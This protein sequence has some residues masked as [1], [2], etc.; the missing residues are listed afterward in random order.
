MHVLVGIQPNGPKERLDGSCDDRGRWLLQSLTGVCADAVPKANALAA[1]VEGL[2]G[3]DS[4]NMLVRDRWL[5]CQ[6]RHVTSRGA[7]NEPRSAPDLYQSL[8]MADF[9]TALP[10]CARRLWPS[11]EIPA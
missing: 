8:R 4:V 7:N 6:P 5:V 3:T 9:M 2:G 11:A 10:T 1:L